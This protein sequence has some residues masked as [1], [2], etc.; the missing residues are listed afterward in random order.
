MRTLLLLLVVPLWAQA[1]PPHIFTAAVVRPIDGDTLRI[2]TQDGER[3]VR[4]YGIDAPEKAQAYGDQALLLLRLLTSGDLVTVTV[5]AQDRYGRLVAIVALP[6]GVVLND[7]LVRVGLAWWYQA[8]AK[9][10]T[11][12]HALEAGARAVR[13][14]LWADPAPI[15]PWAWRKGHR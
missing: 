1:A 12:L 13:R 14:G 15:P 8:Y 6:N 9:K 11:H 3:T 7:E 4:L 2:Q 10:A 5:T